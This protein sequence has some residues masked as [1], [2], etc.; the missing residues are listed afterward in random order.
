M[1]LMPVMGNGN[2]I[3]LFFLVLVCYIISIIYIVLYSDMTK[4]LLKHPRSCQLLIGFLMSDFKMYLGC[5]IFVTES[6]HAKVRIPPAI[7]K[8]ETTI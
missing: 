4:T 1:T 5:N 2:H 7:R 3:S 8:F 6:L